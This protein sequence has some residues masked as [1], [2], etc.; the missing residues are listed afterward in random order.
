MTSKSNLVVFCY[1]N[2]F[3]FVL[4]DITPIHIT[5]RPLVVLGVAYSIV[6]LES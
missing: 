4:P 5:F 2:L 3:T 1:K 6:S